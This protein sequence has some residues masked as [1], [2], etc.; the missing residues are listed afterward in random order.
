M[1]RLTG[2]RWLLLVGVLLGL[3]GFV[4]P[5][6][7]E[8]AAHWSYEGDAGPA[9][10]GELS[11]DFALCST[12]SEQSPVDI[13][14]SAPT[15]ANG[16][17]MS[18]QPSAVNIF[19]NGHT[20]QVNYDD[21]SNLML[22]GQTYK[23]VQFHFHASSEHTLGGQPM[24]MELHMVHRN[25]AGELAVVGTWIKSGSA[26]AAFDPVF[27]NLP[28]TPGDPQAVAGASVNADALLP[29][30]RSYYR[31]NGSLTT[32]PCTEGVKWIMLDTPVEVA[33]EQI[34][35][36]TALFDNNFR[37]TQPLNSREFLTAG[38]A[39]PEPQPVS[40]PLPST[41]QPATPWTAAWIAAACALL[42]VGLFVRRR[43]SA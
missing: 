2:V 16:L 7:A 26:N 8:D 33:P 30:Q 37:P 10:W 6:S 29:S 32:P 9:H 35:A 21:G 18:Y 24:P 36:Y 5:A 41:G 25:D 11:P 43:A 42:L 31:Y 34:A 39:A 19:N 23:L 27:N 3:G 22:D 40:S 13:P 4:R 14:S 38:A 15:N 17:S 12:G 20:I 28:T 1:Q